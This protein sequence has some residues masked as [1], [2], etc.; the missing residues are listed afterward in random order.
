MEH[1]FIT[2]EIDEASPPVVCG[3]RRDAVR[4]GSEHSVHEHRVP[5]EPL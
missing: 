4:S 2:L 1:N 5:A 3:H